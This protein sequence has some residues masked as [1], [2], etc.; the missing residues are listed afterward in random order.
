MTC[1]KCDKKGRIK[2]D[3]K[4]KGNVS[5]GNPSKKSTNELPEW[6]TKKPVVLDTKDIATATI[7]HNNNK[8]KWFTSY[9]NGQGAWGFHW[10][11]FHDG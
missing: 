3:C 4:S 10:N 1:H 5:G 6:V 11:N 9:N 8:Y 7:T 2:K